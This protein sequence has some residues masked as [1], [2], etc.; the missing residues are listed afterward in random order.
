MVSLR[1]AFVSGSMDA[2]LQ[3]TPELTLA[4]AIDI[5][6]AQ[7]AFGRAGILDHLVSGVR[8][9][10]L[11]A[12]APDAQRAEDHLLTALRDHTI[13]VQRVPDEVV[14]PPVAEPAVVEPQVVEPQVVEPQVFEPQAFD[15]HILARHVEIQ[16][17]ALNPEIFQKLKRTDLQG[18]VANL[19]RLGKLPDFAPPDAVAADAAAPEMVVP[20]VLDVA[21]AAMRMAD[22]PGLMQLRGGFREVVAQVEPDGADAVSPDRFRFPTK[23]P[24]ALLTQRLDTGVKESLAGIVA[25][26]MAEL[27]V[28]AVAVGVPEAAAVPFEDLIVD[29]DTVAVALD[30]PGTEQGFV[31]LG[32]REV[33]RRNLGLHVVPPVLRD[34][35]TVDAQQEFDHVVTELAA[36]QIGPA[37]AFPAAPARVT[38]GQVAAH[39]RPRLE[40]SETYR[41][42]LKARLTFVGEGTLPSGAAMG[43]VPRFD[44]PLVERL[45]RSLGQWILAGAERVPPNAITLVLTNPAFVE[46]LIAGANHEVAREMLWRDIPADPR[47]TSFRRFWGASPHEAEGFRA[48]HEWTSRLG[49]NLGAESPYICVVVRSPLLRKYPHAVVQAAQGTLTPRDGGR[50][51]EPDATTITPLLFQGAIAPDLTFSVLA[52]TE[53]QVRE[54]QPGMEWY[55]L[56]GEPVTEPKF[57]LD[58]ERT[59]GVEPQS[60]RDLAWTDVTDGT[61]LRVADA[62]LK[63]FSFEDLPWGRTAAGVARILHQDP[64]R[65]V[66]PAAE[67]LRI[68]V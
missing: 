45:R 43:F 51:F 12:L 40:V 34:L 17:H 49:G 52:L 30:Q 47:G 66:L 61:A 67:F 10:Q 4:P 64:F 25:T 21:V 42:A 26:A 20:A 36:R 54:A 9:E 15:P 27:Q 63:D 24:E 39:I 55:I 68:E 53:E 2:T 19:H 33:V 28:K 23:L 11:F 59:A 44:A 14:V 7:I 41:A 29:R 56:L 38:I 50:N 13:D 46:A 16:P 1:T 60:W 32:A 22:A 35:L 57:G 8:I 62:R 31:Q 18:G 3:P 48:I 65:L 37:I 5:D 6:R 58:S